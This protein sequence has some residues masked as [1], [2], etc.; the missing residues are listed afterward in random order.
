MSRQLILLLFMISLL[1][2]AAC[3]STTS[4]PTSIAIVAPTD[5]AVIAPT[6]EIA[7]T[8]TTVPETETAVPPTSEPTTTPTVTPAETA[9]TASADTAVPVDTS[10]PVPEPSP[11]TPT[12]SNAIIEVEGA[13]VP[14]GFSFKKFTTMYRPTGLAF[15]ENG[16]LYATSFDGSVRIFTD[17]DGDGHA[18]T[19]TNFAG[20]F[21]TPLGVAIRPGT[22]DVYVSSMGT[23]TLLRD[24]TGNNRAD[25][26]VDLITGLPFGLHQ[27]DN[28]KFGPDGMLYMGIGS[29]CDV[30]VENNPRSAT[31][32][33]FNPETGVGD[34]YA[35]GMRNPYD[36]A[37]HPL[38]GEL[39]ATDNGRDDLG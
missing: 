22:N 20:R 33:R 36:L 29:T 31:I 37:F 13:S 16:R 39:F 10:T 12:V 23:V 1:L 9:T 11:T 4:P 32:M 8:P 35:T 28:L 18:D 21:D 15:D 26:R 3:E 38:T 19:E 25:T 5:T 27:N 24:T 6:I 2:L 7:E 14:A 17:D 34:V 30:C